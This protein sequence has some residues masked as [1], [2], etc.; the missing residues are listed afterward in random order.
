MQ[1]LP[2]GKG[3]SV[4]AATD[5]ETPSGWCGTYDSGHWIRAPAKERMAF[6]VRSRAEETI[7]NCPYACVS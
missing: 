2:V 4:D 5:G 7:C 3:K 6:A 1:P